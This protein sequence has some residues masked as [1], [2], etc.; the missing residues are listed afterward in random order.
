V[1]KVNPVKLKQDADK[2]E[3][4]GRLDKAIDLYRQ[5]LQ[6]NPRDWNTIN[7]IG[8][9]YA[10]QNR[11]REASQE[12]AK[13]AD[14]YARDGFLLKAIAIWKKIN[15]LDASALE[16]CLKLA[17][18]Y[19]R[20][21]LLMEA[22]SQYQIVLDEYLKKGKAR[23][24][25][26]VLRKMV[27]I[28]AGDLKLQSR[29]AELYMRMGKKPDAIG[30]YTAI[31]D[32]LNQKGHL[33]EA[34][35]VLQK[36]LK[37]DSTSSQLRVE[38]AKIH[39]VQK[40]FAKAVGVLEEAS[41][42]APDDVSVLAQ[43]GD[44]YLGSKKTDD[45]ERVF[46]RLVDVQPDN[47]EHRIQMGRLYLSKGDLDATY[48]EFSAVA[49][50]YLEREEPGRAIALLD[51]LHGRD[52]DHVKSLVKLVEIYR[53][54]KNDPL[55]IATYSKLTEAYVRRGELEQATSVLEILVD[56]EPQ[57]E[58]HKSKL[59][60]V[61]GQSGRGPAPLS[62]APEEVEPV[63][64]L[65]LG[66]E[67]GLSE[68][69]S[70]PILEPLGDLSVPAAGVPPVTPE[71]PSIE[72][73]GALSE[74]DQEFIEEHL[75]EGRVF[76][77][78]GLVDKAAE[79]FLAV[80]A[81]FPDNVEI[82]E[83]LREVYK[84][85]GDT[86]AAAEQCL[87]LAEIHRL[88]GDAA[89]AK[90]YEDEAHG[91]APG[92]AR[93][94]SPVVEMP[95][96]APE[97][98]SDALGDLLA[99]DEEELTLGDDAEEEFS[100]GDDAEEEF[101]IGDDAEEEFTVGDDA[102]EE[103]TVGD[104]AE[105]LAA[106][107]DA[108]EE[109]FSLGLGADASDGLS[110]GDELD[111]GAAEEADGL[112]LD[113]SVPE[114]TPIVEPPTAPQPL[115]IPQAEK[116]TTVP[117]PALPPGLE[118]ALAE[119]DQY[120]AL[121]FIDDAKQALQKANR[122]YPDHPAI[123]SKSSELGLDQAPASADPFSDLSGDLP[124]L[125]GGWDEALP[126]EIE[127]PSPLAGL[128]EHESPAEAQ[129]AEPEG[130]IDL[131]AELGDILGAQSAVE[132]QPEGAI[133]SELD[134]LGLTEMFKQFKRGVDQQVGQEDFDTRYNLGIAFKEMGLV[135]EAIA[136]FQ[137]AAKD[138]TRQFQCSSML[139]ICFM[140]KGMPQLAVN[141]FEKGLLAQGHSDDEY[142]GLRYDLAAALQASGAIDRA[143]DTFTELYAQDSGFRDVAE[144]LRELK[145]ASP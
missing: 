94:V 36:G 70:A 91:L 130:M 115:Q 21:G 88:R 74:E 78:Y 75:A 114:P 58:Q 5:I 136:E 46:R 30:V 93:A 53:I 134:D 52:P 54:Q 38:L 17:E 102:E 132:P 45:A 79:Q 106:S 44:A 95:A 6:A 118:K 71:R 64:E 48:E 83:E 61:R 34:V 109:E 31:A 82:R 59:A 32:Q 122:A 123:H 111:L 72:L 60:H 19:G 140:E 63:E 113:F 80:A 129:P 85:K 133:S 49:E 8:D 81:R 2:E 16:P 56:M 66:D 62:P 4:A 13:V 37:I 68:V 125:G 101:S 28:D 96:P 121:G 35:Q 65:H 33:A 119:V 29:L 104:D 3:K 41:A 26:E 110:F 15:R 120:V 1:A 103:F 9:L 124:G 47:L 7:K 73:S 14:F 128:A 108:D 92:L 127:A 51:E 126:M 100:I 90:T 22:K 99:K 24:A 20:Q 50:K 77:K 18:L 40:N 98:S 97:A 76:R 107:P 87:A 142:N 42:H 137:L 105:D 116:P 117:L 25:T 145:A 55:V 138:P 135:D 23:D 131:G 143:V 11:A 12:Y 86:K 84:E 27:E 141:W 67:L 112:G 39:L 10:K 57:N 69:S 144:K 43:L 139:G 89:Q